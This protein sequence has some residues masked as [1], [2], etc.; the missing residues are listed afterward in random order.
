MVLATTGLRVG[1]LVA[2]LWPDI[3]LKTRTLRVEKALQRQTGKGLVFVEPKSAQSKR[4]IRLSNV[5]VQALQDHLVLQW[6]RQEAVGTQWNTENLVFPSTV[7]TRQDPRELLRRFHRRGDE[8]GLPRLRL[9]DLRHGVATMLFQRAEHP[10]RVQK[11][12]G[13]STYNTTMDAYTQAGLDDLQSVADA[14]D[15]IFAG[16][17]T[18]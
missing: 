18:A 10:K 5:A 15:D 16:E 4:A 2:L 13:H 12:L 6:Q 7:G 1:E 11:L 8:L 14:M 3:D 17:P 9:H